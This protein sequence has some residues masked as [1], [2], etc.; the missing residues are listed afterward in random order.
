V[1]AHLI[2]RAVQPHRPV[3]WIPDLEGVVEYVRDRLRSGD[4]LATMGAGDVWK[5]AWWVAECL[6]GGKG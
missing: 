1:S 4:V 5:V 6:R 3:V 2:V